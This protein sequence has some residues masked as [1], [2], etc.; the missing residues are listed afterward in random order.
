[1]RSAWSS[2]RID[3]QINLSQISLDGLQSFLLDLIREGIPID[4]FGIESGFTGQVMK[5]CRVI[6]AS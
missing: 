5:G 3:H 4:A 2:Q 1:M 6:P